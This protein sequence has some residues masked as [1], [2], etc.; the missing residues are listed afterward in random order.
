MLS[1]T[2]NSQNVKFIKLC[3]CCFYSQT[4]MNVI[5]L[6]P[7]G[8]ITTVIR[9]HMK[10]ASISLQV[11]RHKITDI[12]WP[13]SKSPYLSTTVPDGRFYVHELLCLVTAIICT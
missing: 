7:K 13:E 4:S 2:D 10:F 12:Y 5:P 11:R 3:S 1:I 6:H 9:T 8:E